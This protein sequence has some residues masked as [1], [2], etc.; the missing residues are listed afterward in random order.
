VEQQGPE[1]VLRHK[2]WQQAAGSQQVILPHHLGQ[3]PR[4]HAR[5][6][7]LMRG[8]RSGRSRGG[9][10]DRLVGEEIPLVGGGHEYEVSARPGPWKGIF[11]P[12]PILG[13]NAFAPP[14]RA[15]TP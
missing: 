11:D 5:R 2:A 14:V 12:Y 13:G 8:T 10:R 4:S 6:E 15:G 1:A 9:R 7:R 3:A